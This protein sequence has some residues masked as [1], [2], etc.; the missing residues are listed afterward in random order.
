MHAYRANVYAAPPLLLAAGDSGVGAGL[1]ENDSG[2]RCAIAHD[3]GFFSVK[4]Y[5]VLLGAFAVFDLLH[6]GTGHGR[7]AADGCIDWH[8][9]RHRIPN[10]MGNSSGY[11]TV[12]RCG[13]GLFSVKNSGIQPPRKAIP[14]F[15]VFAD[16]DAS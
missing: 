11:G 8:G 10:G 14:C 7:T 2:N 9:C 15:S 6:G 4:H 5:I 13:A 16:S 12:C 1:S 3:R